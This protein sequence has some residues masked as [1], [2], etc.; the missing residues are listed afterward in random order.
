MKYDV[1]I[2]YDKMLDGNNSFFHMH[3]DSAFSP[4]FFIASFTRKPVGTPI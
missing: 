2:Q 1:Y 3:E 4:N